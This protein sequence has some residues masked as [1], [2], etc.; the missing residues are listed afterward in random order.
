[1]SDAPRL[2][3]ACAFRHTV[4]PTWREEC[5][6]FE[7]SDGFRL[8]GTVSRR[9]DGGLTQ[10]RYEIGCA[11]DWTTRSA[12]ITTSGERSGSL[13]LAASHG[14][15]IANGGA[16]PALDGC[17]DI[18]LAFTP[19]TNT[20]PIRR[21]GLSVGEAA[22]VRAAWVRVPNLSVEPLAQTY[23]RLGPLRY[24]YQSGSGPLTLEVDE[25]GLVTRYATWIRE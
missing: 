19:S 15:W 8:Q 13:S 23:T 11:P 14:R 7:S 2:L 4:D 17:L 22:Q 12:F 1:M 3:R 5:R 16:Q 21:L 18:D 24:E 9:L 10:A 6:L 25:L 20:L